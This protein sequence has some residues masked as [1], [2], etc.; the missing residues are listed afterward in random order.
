VRSVI[1]RDESTVE[2][3]TGNSTY[4]LELVRG[5]EKEQGDV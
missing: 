2:I 4:R 5:D 1:Q 3:A